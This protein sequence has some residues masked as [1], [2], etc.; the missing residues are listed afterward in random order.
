M[1]NFILPF[2]FSFKLCATLACNPL[3]LQVLGE[4]Q[5]PAELPS[6]SLPSAALSPRHNRANP[7][8]AGGWTGQGSELYPQ[9]FTSCCARLQGSH[10]AQICVNAAAPPNQFAC[11][12]P[13]CLS[14]CFPAIPGPHYQ[15]FYRHGTK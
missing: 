11:S 12:Q 1:C 2:L 8:E 14:L 15:G 5:Q 9:V 3:L 4:K 13:K 10:T 6:Q 7:P